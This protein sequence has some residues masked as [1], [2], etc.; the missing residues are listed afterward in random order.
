MNQ[1]C[2]RN[3]ISVFAKEKVEKNTFIPE[4]Q[5]LLKA[6]TGDLKIKMPLMTGMKKRSASIGFNGRGFTPTPCSRNGASD[7]KDKTIRPGDLV[8]VVKAHQCCGFSRRIDVV[9]RVDYMAGGPNSCGNCGQEFE[10]VLD[11]WSNTFDWSSPVSNLIKINPPA[12]GETREA[13]NEL[14]V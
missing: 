5:I 11:A 2:R 12:E 7:M 13:Y 9:F 6:I 10:D 1:K 8:M 14:T 3:L 4:M